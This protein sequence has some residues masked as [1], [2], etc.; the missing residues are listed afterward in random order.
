VFTARSEARVLAFTGRPLNRQNQAPPA[1]RKSKRKKC[2][3]LY[4]R[5][6]QAVNVV[7]PVRYRRRSAVGGQ[8]SAVGQ[9]LN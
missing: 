8:L 6:A 7:R 4:E 5:R 2:G 9:Q 1:V 3:G